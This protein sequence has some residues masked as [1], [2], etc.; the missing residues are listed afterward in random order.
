MT[1]TLDKF[2]R[3]STAENIARINLLQKEGK[4]TKEWADAA[5]QIW[6]DKLAAGGRP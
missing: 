3:Q 2:G 6:K 5:R 4:V 1:L